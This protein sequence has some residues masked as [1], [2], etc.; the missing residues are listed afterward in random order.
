MKGSF[1]SKLGLK[2]FDLET[3]MVAKYATEQTAV[4]AFE[5]PPGRVYELYRP[6]SM[7][8]LFFDS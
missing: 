2:A 8:G 6:S 4:I 7:P 5:L 3:S 1:E